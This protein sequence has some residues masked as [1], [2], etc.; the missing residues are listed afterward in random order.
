MCSASRFFFLKSRRYFY[1]VSPSFKY[2]DTK[3]ANRIR[4]KTTSYR[5]RDSIR[6]LRL[7]HDWSHGFSPQTHVWL[8]GPF[9]QS[10]QFTRAGLACEWWIFAALFRLSRECTV[11]EKVNT[12]QINDGIKRRGEE[13]KLWITAFVLISTTQSRG[14]LSGSQSNSSTSQ[15]N[16]EPRERLRVCPRVSSTPCA[17][18]RA[19]K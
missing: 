11:R 8:F 9:K 14:G 10:A 19:C 7:E 2:S 1:F 5:K 3:I 17:C 6:A 16:E 18:V 13:R 4:C 12:W 15:H